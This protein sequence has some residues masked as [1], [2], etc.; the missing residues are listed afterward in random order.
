[1][2]LSDTDRGF[3]GTFGVSGSGFRHL[4][5]Y[6]TWPEGLEGLD[7]DRNG[8]HSEQVL[9][10]RAT[11]MTGFHLHRARLALASTGSEP[12]SLTLQVK[13]ALSHAAIC[14]S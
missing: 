14:C 3:A 2:L 12:K 11:S 5:S 9:P 8:R 13:G 10:S 1:M 4:G 7:D 6:E